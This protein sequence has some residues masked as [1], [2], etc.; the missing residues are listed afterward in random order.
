[1]DYID[2]LKKAR[3]DKNLRQQDVSEHLGIAKSTYSM[4]ET[5]KNKM[6]I[7]TFAELC[8]LFNVTPNEMLGF[9]E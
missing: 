7:E 9:D 4:Y 1:M 8:R 3:L 2:R 5:R 6:D